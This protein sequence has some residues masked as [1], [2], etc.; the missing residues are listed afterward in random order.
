MMKSMRSKLLSY[1]C[2]LLGAAALGACDAKSTDASPDFSAP[3]DAARADSQPA[4]RPAPEAPDD[5]QPEPQPAARPSATSPRDAQVALKPPLD[6]S[7]LLKA[8]DLSA[9][10][11]AKI[12]SEKIAGAAATPTYNSARFFAE[13]SQ[14]Y[15]VGL[16]VWTFEEPGDALE[17]VA[18]MRAQYLGVKDAPADAP[19]QGERGFLAA[20][21]GIENYIFTPESGAHYVLALSCGADLCPNGW[22]DLN[23]LTSTVAARV[24]GSEEAP[25]P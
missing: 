21:A 10:T 15:G 8:E 22:A 17:F 18:K 25:A 2:A 6:I 24:G 3:A 1:T 5:P 19:A 7:G 11:T 13:D 23:A 9:L 12:S 14:D 20:R 16:Q 4:P